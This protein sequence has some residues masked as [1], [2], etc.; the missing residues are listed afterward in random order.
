MNDRLRELRGGTGDY[1]R[2][3]DDEEMRTASRTESKQ[4]IRLLEP[5]FSDVEVITVIP[6]INL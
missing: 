3:D 4:N 5:F 6:C 1:A 2:M